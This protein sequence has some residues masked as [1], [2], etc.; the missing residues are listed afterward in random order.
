LLA[1]ILIPFWPGCC[2]GEARLFIHPVLLLDLT[3]PA[4]LSFLTVCQS[5]SVKAGTFS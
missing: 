4:A 2:K 5:P 1:T 3:T